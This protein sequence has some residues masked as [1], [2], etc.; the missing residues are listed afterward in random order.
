VAAVQTLDDPKARVQE[1]GEVWS[2]EYV[3]HNE[4]AGE[5]FSIITSGRKTEELST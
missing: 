5:R 3:I 2:G 1:L 4:E